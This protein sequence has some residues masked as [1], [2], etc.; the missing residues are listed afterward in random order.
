M[1]S[2]TIHDLDEMLDSH[3]REKARRQGISLNRTIKRLLQESLGIAQT[4][5]QAKK[6]QFQD[7]FGVWSDKDEREFNLRTKSFEK[8]D[9][10]DW[11]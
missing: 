6:N 5:Q 8:V 11:R 7:L 1:R 3:I 9:N 10:K 4:N 2:I